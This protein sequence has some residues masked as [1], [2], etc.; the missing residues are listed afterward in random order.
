ME[1]RLKTVRQARGWSQARLM[2]ELERVGQARGTPVPGRASLKT[3]V[4]R[5]ENGHVVPDELYAALLAEVYDTT[6]ADLGL[7]ASPAALCLHVRSQ[8]AAATPEFL[9]AMDSMLQEYA[10]ADNAVGSGHLLGAVAHQVTELE[11][12]ALNARGNLR[13]EALALCSRFSEFAGWLGQDAGD[14]QQAE[15]WTDR[16]LDFVESVDD[17]EARSYVLMRKSAIAAERR[18]PARAVSLAEGSCRNHAALSSRMTALAFRQLA[19]GHA[20][21]GD[22]LDAERA[23]AAAMTSAFEGGTENGAMAYCTPSFV[24]METGF[25]AARL[26][27]YDV[28][29]DRLAEAARLWPDAFVRDRGLCLVRLALVEAI[30]GNLE[31][32]CSVGK[33]A[34]DLAVVAGSARTRATFRSLDARLAAHRGA[35]VVSEFKAYSDQLS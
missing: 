29:A 31:V 3:Q 21:A 1:T 17:L 34:V 28:A 26:H 18:E 6:P 14:L 24:L 15:R 2:L 11:L 19:I 35:T 8:P 30:R 9:A 12:M 16:A 32:A 23:A 33:A 20:L 4:S 27:Q 22:A 5:W 7:E 25:A 10:R 13:T